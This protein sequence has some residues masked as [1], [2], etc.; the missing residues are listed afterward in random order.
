MNKV[1]TKPRKDGK[2][3]LTAE[4]DI[5]DD[6]MVFIDHSHASIDALLTLAHSQAINQS[7]ALMAQTA[8][9]NYARDREDARNMELEGGPA[10]N[11]LV[12][13]VDFTDDDAMI[14]W[15]KGQEGYR[16]AKKM[17]EDAKAAKSNNGQN[18]EAP[19]TSQESGDQQ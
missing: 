5:N 16:S 8:R 12:P 19:P 11:V 15:L 1:R 2:A 13:L 17:D 3:G 10:A 7:K 18:V 9:A 14:N 4:I 6:D